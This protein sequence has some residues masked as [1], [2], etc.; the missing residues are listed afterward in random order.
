MVIALG[1]ASICE[2]LAVY[3]DS[4]NGAMQ[5]AHVVGL[6]V[7]CSKEERQTAFP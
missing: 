4:L 1:V 6:Q 5:L 2:I 7:R 3:L